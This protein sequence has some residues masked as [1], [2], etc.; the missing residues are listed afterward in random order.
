M[1]RPLSWPTQ[2]WT[3]RKVR[4]SLPGKLHLT[5]PLRPATDDVNNYCT[6]LRPGG[7]WHLSPHPCIS[8]SAAV[9]LIA[10]T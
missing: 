3:Q 4:A 8:L 1:A 6:Q 5:L 9:T 7:A 10:Q 2:T